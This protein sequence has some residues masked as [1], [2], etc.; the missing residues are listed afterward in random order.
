MSLGENI[1]AA[2]KISGLS[3]EALGEKLGVVSQTVSKWERGESAPDAALLPSLAD[4]LGVSLDALFD[5]TPSDKEME[6]NLLAWLRPKTEDERSESLLRFHRLLLELDIGI[7]GGA[8]IWPNMPAD[9]RY[10]YL[11]EKTVAFCAR[12]PENPAAFIFRKPKTGWAALFQDPEEMHLIWEALGDAETRQVTLRILSSPERCLRQEALEKTLGMTKPLDTVPR[13]VGLGL[14]H[15][16]TCPVDGED[17]K[18]YWTVPDPR[19]LSILLMA[20]LLWLPFQ[21]AMVVSGGS[22]GSRPPLAEESA[23]TDENG[24]ADAS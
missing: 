3:Q 5:R 15:V 9:I 6:K 14:M 7:L 11:G 8:V 4:A 1:H 20:R 16:H 10:S 22:W 13:L 12:D 2:R 24:G 23:A 21:K 18:L 19:V 17:T